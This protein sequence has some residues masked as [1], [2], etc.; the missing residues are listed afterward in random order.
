ML[1]L[2]RNGAYEHLIWVAVAPTTTTIRQAPSIVLLTPED[3]GVP[4]RCIVTLDNIQVAR[5][6]WLSEHITTL[7]RERMVEIEEAI[8]FALALPR[9]RSTPAPL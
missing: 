6:A 4:A 3:D 7:S 5:P 9:Q 1:L 8:H 2:A